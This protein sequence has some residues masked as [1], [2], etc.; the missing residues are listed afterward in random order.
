MQNKEPADLQP[1][2]EVYILYIFEWDKTKAETNI[3]KH[4]VSF[5]EAQSVFYDEYALMIPDEG[6]SIE[7]DRFIMLGLSSKANVLVVCYCE[8]GKEGNTIRI[9]SSRKA[10]KRESAQYWAKRVK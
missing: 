1:E 10:N 8:R 6:H 2:K 5:E 7:E 9:I 4:K 3:K